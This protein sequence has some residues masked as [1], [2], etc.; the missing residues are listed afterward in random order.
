M[1]VLSKEIP[2]KKWVCGNCTEFN[3]GRKN[4]SILGNPVDPQDYLC[5]VGLRYFTDRG[6]TFHPDFTLTVKESPTR[7]ASLLKI[8]YLHDQGEFH[9]K[10]KLGLECPD[11]IVDYIL[12]LGDIYFSLAAEVLKRP[13]TGSSNFAY[14]TSYPKYKYLDTS[15]N[16]EGTPCSLDEMRQAS[17]LINPTKVV[18][19]DFLGDSEKTLKA[20]PEAT[21][22]FG[23]SDLLPVVQGSS[24]EEVLHC[25][26]VIRGYNFTS[27]AVPYDLILGK[28]QP[29]NRM[30]RIRSAIVHYLVNT[31]NFNSIHLL[32]LT[33]LEELY[34]YFFDKPTRDGIDSLDTGGPVLLGL[35]GLRYPTE[36]IF[37]KDPTLNL[38]KVNPLAKVLD[39]H[40]TEVGRAVWNIAFLKTLL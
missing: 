20:L 13:V 27:L 38:M 24:L 33:S 8:P 12:P 29:V 35:N 26:H 25:A 7:K 5:C 4:C 18:A 31:L 21:E 39:Y 3:L 19:Q 10:I 16:E 40:D 11:S 2:L 14:I 32:G 34:L 1:T 9:R 6:A 28:M 15:V 17:F 36:Y 23:R 30:A 37:K 22:A